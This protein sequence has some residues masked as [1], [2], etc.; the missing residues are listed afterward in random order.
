MEQKKLPLKKATVTKKKAAPK[1]GVP[2]KKTAVGL[3]DEFGLRLEN[4]CPET[5]ADDLG[6]PTLFF[7]PEDDS[8]IS[9]EPGAGGRMVFSDPDGFYFEGGGDLT[10]EGNVFAQSFGQTS[11]RNLK[12]NVL[13]I[14]D[15][16]EKIQGLRGVYF[17]W[18]PEHGGQADFGFIAEEVAE[19]FPQAT[20]FEADGTTPKGVKY[21]NMVAVLV[22]AVKEQQNEIQEL[23]EELQNQN[24]ALHKE[25]KDLKQLMTLQLAR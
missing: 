25:I 19:V 12:E 5:G 23:Q 24:A 17:D 2:T 8:T 13:T 9:S 20:I 6:S 14:T 1:P 15:A 11:A 18:K 4:D 16:K 21:A 22:E 10:V 7:G 3:C